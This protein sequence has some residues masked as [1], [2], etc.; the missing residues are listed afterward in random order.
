MNRILGIIIAGLI[1]SSMV[2]LGHAVQTEDPFNTINSV[3]NGTSEV[4]ISTIGKENFKTE[5]VD[6]KSK[7][8]ASKTIDDAKETEKIHP[9]IKEWLNSK[10]PSEKVSI[11]INLRDDAII[12]R[13]PESSGTTRD[14]PLGTDLRIQRESIINDLLQK[15][16]DSQAPILKTFEK[17]G[18]KLKER[19]WIVNG[20]LAEVPIKA[21]GQIAEHNDVVYIQPEIGGEKP[22]AEVTDWN[23][24]NDVDD[25]RARI[26]SDPYFNLPGMTTSYIGLLDTGVRDSH[27]LFQSPDHIDFMRDCVNGGTN[28]NTPWPGFNPQDLCNHGTSSAAIITGNGRLG[29]AYRGV[30]AITLDSWKVYSGS[31]TGC[32][33]NYAA[34]LRAFQNGLWAAD[35]V[36]VAEMQAG[37]AENGIIAT[38]ADNTFNAGAV[39][40]A[41]NGNYGPSASTVASPAIAHKVIGAGAYDVIGLWT[42]GYQSRGPATDGRW[43]PDIQTPTNT[44]T[45]SSASNTAL[46]V[47]GG[48]SGSTPYASG[49]AALARNWLSNRGTYDPG[50]TYSMLIMSGQR[51]WCCY[52]NE[53]G[54]GD[55]KLPLGGWAY[56]GKV[57]ISGTGS[58]INIPIYVGSGKTLMEASLWWPEKPGE[59]HDDVDVHLIDPYGVERAKG[60]DIVSVFENTKFSGSL[61]PGTWKI[62]IKGFYVPSGPQT[63]YWFARIK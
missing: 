48:T 9:K 21:I 27:I 15:R 4:K 37:E 25:G 32:G 33:L 45:A 17:L 5:D 52:N 28:C 8:D 24:Y 14:S 50:Q 40:I 60:Y 18:L 34:V 51:K 2:T 11:L 16:T 42:P 57:S 59:S 43:K 10:D 30:T 41:A 58:T 29:N 36:F 26:Q 22:P 39:V 35:K 56:W 62:R 63:V 20:F 55:L 3:E 19:Y 53:E 44:E 12:P 61:T 6:P 54:A 1:L 31:G 38:A 46:R 7:P 49:A 13:L 47:F 23:Y